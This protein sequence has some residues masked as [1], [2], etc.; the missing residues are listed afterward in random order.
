M[1]LGALLVPLA[2]FGH[3]LIDAPIFFGPVLVLTLWILWMGR[4]DRNQRSG[5]Q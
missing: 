5:R 4:R 2:H 3:V 1:T